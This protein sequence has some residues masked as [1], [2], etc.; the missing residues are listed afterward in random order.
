[1]YFR[2]LKIMLKKPEYVNT[3]NFLDTNK[4]ISYRS[5]NNQ[6]VYKP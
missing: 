3:N 2:Y 4:L 6:S 1:M 5:P